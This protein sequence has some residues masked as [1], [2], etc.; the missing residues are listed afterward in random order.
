MDE[1]SSVSVPA[2]DAELLNTIRSGD[3]GAHA[4]LRRRHRAA[5]R[6]LAGQLVS[7]PAAADDLVASVFTRVLDAIR[8]G[9]GPT[10]AFRPY[11]LT[12]VRRAARDSF[13]GDPAEI[14]TD[15][16]RISDPGQPFDPAAAGPQAAPL[17]AAFVSLPERWRA[18]LWHT[19]IER[20]A[21]SEVAPLLALNARGVTELA[22]RARDGLHQAY[23]QLQAA[24][25]GCEYAD[26]ADIG[27]ALRGTVAPMVLGDAAAAYLARP[28][29]SA[30][31]PSS[32]GSPG[33][34]KAALRDITAGT[35]VTWPP[36]KLRRSSPRRAL[37]ACAL[38]AIFGIAAYAVALRP[39][40]GPATASGSQTAAGALG[41]P[42]LPAPTAAPTRRPVRP[43]AARNRDSSLH[44]PP[45]AA[46][47]A[48]PTPGTPTEQPRPQPRPQPLA[49]PPNPALM[50][51]WHAPGVRGWNCIP[52]A[53]GPACVHVPIAA[54]DRSS[55]FRAGG[56]APGWRETSGQQATRQWPSWHAPT[57]QYPS[58]HAPTRPGQGAHGRG[59]PRN[60]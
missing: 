44:Q 17:I 12:A 22:A 48:S 35:A 20:A 31:S 33:A 3:P 50:T 37:A 7:G 49:A 56:G 2:S 26:I 39:G 13:G 1:A 5:A 19:E 14:P 51:G 11:L 36:S 30:G 46:A 54:A 47:G 53:D 58:W 9:G 41:P 32:A 42:T 24:D 16:Q 57:R 23:L 34:G 4:L 55:G 8:R 40:A 59:W 28:A 38:L 45:P 18:V 29:G 21:P 25:A 15:E 60:G 6:R 52:A 43:P 10:D 27:A